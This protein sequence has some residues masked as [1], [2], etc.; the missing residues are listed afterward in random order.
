MA[1][2]GI[3]PEVPTNFQKTGLAQQKR[4][5]V[6]KRPL[7]LVDS[8]KGRFTRGSVDSEYIEGRGGRV[9][10]KIVSGKAAMFQDW[11]FDAE[12]HVVAVRVGR[13]FNTRDYTGDLVWANASDIFLRRGDDGKFVVRAKS[14]SDLLPAWNREFNTAKKRMAAS[15][16]Q[17]G[18]A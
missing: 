3:A 17:V 9:T 18:L 1:E 16:P 4:V 11:D 8:F 2:D 10:T 15:K 12:G 6:A 13:V 14:I 5:E 7:G